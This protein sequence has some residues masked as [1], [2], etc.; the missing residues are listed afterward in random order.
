M[1]D[2]LLIDDDPIFNLV[3]KRIIKHADPESETMSLPSAVDA[4]E[5][6]KGLEERGEK[7]PDIIFVDLIMPVLTGIEFLDLVAHRY[8]HFL[9]STKVYVLSTTLN[10]RDRKKAM[11]HEIVSGFIEKPITV[12]AA[13]SILSH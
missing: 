1:K 9:K 7:C 3:T 4:L 10:E 6:I 2:I 13:K 11:G 5:H 8:S 12:S